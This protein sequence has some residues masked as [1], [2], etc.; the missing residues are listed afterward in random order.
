MNPEYPS[1]S[2]S[3][4]LSRKLCFIVTEVGDSKFTGSSAAFG[5]LSGFGFLA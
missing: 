3:D 4:Y 2:L 1:N 5:D